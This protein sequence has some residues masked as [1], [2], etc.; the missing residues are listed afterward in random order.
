MPL[1]CRPGRKR[2]PLCI[3]FH[4]RQRFL[5]RLRAAD[6]LPVCVHHFTRRNLVPTERAEKSQVQMF[7]G[8]IFCV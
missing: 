7:A 6:V 8:Q 5:A 4:L 2:P 3:T 1:L